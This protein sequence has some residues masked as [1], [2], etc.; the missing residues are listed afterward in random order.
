M[1]SFG[2]DIET[3]IIGEDPLA[4]LFGIRKLR[5]GDSSMLIDDSFKQL[6]SIDSQSQVISLLEKT[7]LEEN[8]K[9]YKI[10]NFIKIEDHVSSTSLYC[11][12]DKT[13]LVLGLKPSQNLLEL[14]RKF[15]YLFNHNLFLEEEWNLKKC[16]DFDKDFIS[17]IKRVGAHACQYS[18]SKKYNLNSLL[19]HCPPRIRSIFKFF[20]NG[21]LSGQKQAILSKHFLEYRSLLFLIR[22]THQ[23]TSSCKFSETQLFYL[24]LSLLS[25]C[26]TLNESTLGESLKNQ[27][28]K[29]GGVYKQS[30]INDYSFNL[31]KPWRVELASIEGTLTPKKICFFNHLNPSYHMDLSKQ[32]RA[33]HILEFSFSL[34][35]SIPE[36]TQDNLILMTKKEYLGTHFPYLEARILKGRIFFKVY[37][38]KQDTEKVEFVKD[39]AMDFLKS[40]INDEL[41]FL[42]IDFNDYNLENHGISQIFALDNEQSDDYNSIDVYLP[43]LPSVFLR[44]PISK[45]KELNDVFY[46]GP[47]GYC[48][49]GSFSNLI[50]LTHFEC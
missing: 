49:L 34:S 43:R 5:S 1:Y 2:Q 25:P 3:L 8:I 38:T 20:A 11:I 22:A 30:K 18:D 28:I 6:N 40:Y 36:F 26:F 4:Y 44:T 45:S 12:A 37:Y 24:F 10:D 42:V 39:A 15:P 21:V 46:F 41:K 9:N 27:Y 48:Q 35:G 32:G 17:L 13:K 7:F 50:N 23:H 14:G 29:L 19:L 47:A 31:Q 33:F 16:T